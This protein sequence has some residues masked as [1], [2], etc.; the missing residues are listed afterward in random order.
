MKSEDNGRRAPEEQRMDRDKDWD[1]SRPGRTGR[2]NRI[3]AARER[4]AAKWWSI[5]ALGS[6]ALWN[7]WNV[8]VLVTRGDSPAI[9]FVSAVLMTTV[10]VVAWRRWPG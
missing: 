3:N 6:G 5:F 2:R 9:A 1:A 8:A 4:S 10:A 7:A